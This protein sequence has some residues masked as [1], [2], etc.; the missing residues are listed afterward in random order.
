METVATSVSSS[1][2]PTT[3]TATTTPP[4]SLRAQME[5]KK[6][7]MAQKIRKHQQTMAA[8]MQAQAQEREEERRKNMDAAS[9]T[10]AKENDRKNAKV[11]VGTARKVRVPVTLENFP[12]RTDRGLDEPLLGGEEFRP[13]ASKEEDG[14][15]LCEGCIVS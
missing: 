14:S 3:A 7:L 11:A 10:R 2:R 8:S 1:S 5:E 15:L 13:K 6:R 9:T 4:P 12:L